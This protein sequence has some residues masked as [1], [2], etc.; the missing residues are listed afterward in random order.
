MHCWHSVPTSSTLLL[1]VSMP[2]LTWDG[3][4]ACYKQMLVVLLTQLETW[5]TL[6]GLS[7]GVSRLTSKYW[8]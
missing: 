2:I 7:Y 1:S 6:T 4:I 5:F 3:Y 8:R